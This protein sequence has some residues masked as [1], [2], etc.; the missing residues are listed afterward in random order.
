ME[1][2]HIQHDSSVVVDGDSL[3][4]GFS[5]RRMQFGV[6]FRDD[7]KLVNATYTHEIEYLENVWN[8]P[9]T[10]MEKFNI[11]KTTTHITT[12]S[13]SLRKRSRES[14]EARNRNE[15]DIDLTERR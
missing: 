5:W 15:S 7:V 2:H 6:D 12:N 3:S 14:E 1:Y 13:T 11:L 9:N 10:T 4:E 8:I